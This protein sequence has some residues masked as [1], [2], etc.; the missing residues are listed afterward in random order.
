MRVLYWLIRAIAWL[1][2]L[3]AVAVA[4]R[5]G[6][7]WLDTRAWESVPFGQVW[8]DLHKDSLLLVQPALERH[9]SAF[10][11]DPVMTTILEAPAWLVF[12]APGIVL[13]LLGSLRRRGRSRG[14]FRS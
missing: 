2:I 4:V 6:F 8:F 14:K 12:G 5:D 9:V 13:L 11:W 7:A 3:A 1:L 10:L